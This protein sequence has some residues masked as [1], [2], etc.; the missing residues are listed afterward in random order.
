MKKTLLLGMPAFLLV[1]SLVLTACPIGNDD[2]KLSP[3]ETS[4]L[5]TIKIADVK[6]EV[7]NENGSPI[8]RN[9]TADGKVFFED[10]EVGTMTNG[11]LTATIPVPASLDELNVEEAGYLVG[12]YNDEDPKAVLSASD[13]K[14]AT[15]DLS[16]GSGN[17]AKWLFR[18]NIES[19]NK[20]Y[21]RSKSIEYVYVDK[22]VT[23]SREQYTY[24]GVSYD[25]VKIALKKGWNL[26]QNTTDVKVISGSVEDG[27]AKIS[28][29][30]KYAI[31][32]DD[33]Q[34]VLWSYDDNDN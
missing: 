7:D 22:D 23:I 26:I 12:T 28:G 14:F 5:A 13:A 32:A 20:T 34:W 25:E 6:D 16:L 11:K 10:K 3:L 31:A 30:E 2:G 17:T 33:V 4:G 29:S 24:D 27:T 8:Y 9:S 18:E 1:F 21:D 19:D 15:L